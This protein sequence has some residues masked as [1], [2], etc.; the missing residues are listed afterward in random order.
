LLEPQVLACFDLQQKLEQNPGRKK[1]KIAK[2]TIIWQQ[3]PTFYSGES[4]EA[5]SLFILF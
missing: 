1:R 2:R 3:K 4:F 5:A